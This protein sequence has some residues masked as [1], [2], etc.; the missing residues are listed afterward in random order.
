LEILAKLRQKLFLV[1]LLAVVVKVFFA[2]VVFNIVPAGSD[3]DRGTEASGRGDDRRDNESP[4][5]RRGERL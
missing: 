5:G 1:K 4:S 2:V 3:G